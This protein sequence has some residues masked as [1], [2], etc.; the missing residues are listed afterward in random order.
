M[1]GWTMQVLKDK[2]IHVGENGVGKVLSEPKRKP[3]TEAIVRKVLQK[4]QFEYNE[5]TGNK[6]KINPKDHITFILNFL[7]LEYVPE[8]KF[9]KDRKFRFDWA[10]PSLKAA[11]EYEGI[12]GKKSRH[13]TF[14]G[15]STDTEKYRLAA[16]EGWKVLRYTVS[17]YKCLEADLNRLMQ[18]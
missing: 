17:N 10:I 6:N 4:T 12:S 8:L 16:I 5:H 7:E 3:I 1:K 14:S 9:S 15:Y 18:K 11:I 2:K 13:T